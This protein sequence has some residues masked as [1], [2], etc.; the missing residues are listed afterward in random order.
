MKNQ[1]I[2]K[3]AFKI[4]LLYPVWIIVSIFSIAYVPTL[5]FVQDDILST[6]NNVSK[7]EMLFR[8][9]IIGSFA[10]GVL[11]IYVSYY[12]Y[13][14][15]ESV[16]K[17]SAKLMLILALLSIPFLGF[18]VFKIV[19]LGSEN[20]DYI[21]NCLSL[22]RNAQTVAEVFWGLWLFPL[23][24]LVISSN[25]FPNFLGYALIA[26]GIGYL[27]GVIIKV[28]FPSESYLLFLTDTLAFGELVFALWFVFKGLSLEYV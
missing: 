26:S 20:E 1:S 21:Y 8:W 17:N 15:F 9:S 3:I 2:K 22:S 12:L 6:A 19:S 25:Y 28:V 5:I 13:L 7:H 14:L 24:K 11:M 18:D 27:F 16:N 23:G 10:T 4:R